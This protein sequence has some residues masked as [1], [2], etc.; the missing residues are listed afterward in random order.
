MTTPSGQIQASDINV[1]LGRPWNAYFELNDGAVRNLAQRGGGYIDMN[2]LR[3][4]SSY[5]PMGGYA[6]H[7]S[8]G[9]PLYNQSQPFQS[10]IYPSVGVSNGTQPYSYQWSFISA[11][12]ATFPG[13]TNGSSVA[14]RH[15]ISRYGY[16]GESSL[17]CVVT[18]AT[19]RTLTIAPVY[20]SWDYYD[21]N[22]DPR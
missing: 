21:G 6:N 2:D 10:T 7:D 8:A 20:A 14:V 15:S 22:Q 9:G 1:E 4:K 19:G 5:T 13:A 3:G 18:D 16:Q 11:N 12:G 17:Q